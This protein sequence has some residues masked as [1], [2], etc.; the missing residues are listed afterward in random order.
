MAMHTGNTIVRVFKDHQAAQEA[1]R[2]LK[3]AG[4]RDDQIGV[5]SSNNE[6]LGT[7]TES[8]D[9]PISGDESANDT[10]AGE[11]A[12]GGVAAGAE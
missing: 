9:E 8:D 10:Y 4:F 7:H 12:F 1:V 5:A 3:A 2:R 6:G 11:G